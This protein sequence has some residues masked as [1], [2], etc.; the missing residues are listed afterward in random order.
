MIW[1]RKGREPACKVISVNMEVKQVRMIRRWTVTRIYMINYEHY[2][3]GCCFSKRGCEGSGIHEVDINKETSSAINEMEK[4]FFSTS[5]DRCIF[6]FSTAYDR[7]IFAFSTAYNRC[8]FAL[9]VYDTGHVDWW[10]K[11]LRTT[12]YVKPAYIKGCGIF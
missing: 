7:C 4:L 10:K 9:C 11:V 6:A 2:C 12:T 1:G 5:Y 8:I 3:E